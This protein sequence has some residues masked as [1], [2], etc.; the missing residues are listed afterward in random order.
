MFSRGGGGF[1]ERFCG[2]ALLEVSFR[3]RF[4]FFYCSISISQ[5]AVA[6]MQ[7]DCFVAFRLQSSIPSKL[8]EPK[9]Y[10]ST[11]ICDV[12]K[13]NQLFD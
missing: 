13:Y 2:V 6:T 5:Y 8:S 11:F 9:S 10:S 4:L 1:F 12:Y 3:G 7:K